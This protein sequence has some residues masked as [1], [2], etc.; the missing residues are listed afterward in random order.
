MKETSRV[1]KKKNF[2]FVGDLKC[3]CDENFVFSF[4]VFLSVIT[5]LDPKLLESANFFTI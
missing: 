3:Y 4:P 5:F 2:R 1:G